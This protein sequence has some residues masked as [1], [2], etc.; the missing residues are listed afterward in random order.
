M[1]YQDQFLEMLQ[2]ERALK[3]NS[4]TSYKCDLK[5][6]VEFLEIFELDQFTISRNDID[7]YILFLSRDKK[8][9]ARS[10]NRKI[11]AIRSYYEFLT[12]EK[13]IDYNPTTNID[14][15][16]YHLNIPDILSIEDIKKLL[17]YLD[18]KTNSHH[19][20]RLRAMIYLLYASGMRVTEL[21]SLKIT[22]ILDVDGSIKKTFLIKGKN[23]KERFVIINE[24]TINTL[25]EYIK[26]R[27]D[28]LPSK[29]I[30]EKTL[31]K[32]GKNNKQNLISNVFFD[33][34]NEQYLWPTKKRKNHMTRQNF[35]KLLKKAAFDA[36]LENVNISPH[37]LRH[38]FATHILKQGGN[39]RLLQEL[40]GHSDISTTQIYTK[41]YQD[42]IK[43][44]MDRFH[45]INKGIIKV[46]DTDK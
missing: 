5:N 40:L 19:E 24:K 45:P 11:S 12:T 10:I 34:D 1:E 18:T 7:D 23:D 28:F 39:L 6:F 20:I 13:H 37:I 17:D 26:I 38:S 35:A 9:S 21:V 22:D 27:H 41:I 31:E 30:L 29:Y 32:K 46:N 36:K 44:A 4:L 25:K 33:Y 43:E 42:S 16:K 14:T 2:T 3:E 15:P 8:L